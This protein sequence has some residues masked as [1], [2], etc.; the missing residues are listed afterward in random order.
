MIALTLSDSDTVSCAEILC[1]NLDLLNNCRNYR[2]RDMKVPY[3]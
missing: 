3:E 1:V 2:L